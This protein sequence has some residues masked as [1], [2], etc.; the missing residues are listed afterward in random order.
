MVAVLTAGA[1]V[2]V[3]YQI[4]VVFFRHFTGKIKLYKSRIFVIVLGYVCAVFVRHKVSVPEGYSDAVKS[5]SFNIF[6]ILFGDVIVTVAFKKLCGFFFP[7]KK[8]E[9]I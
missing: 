1:A 6:K 8:R 9:F 2:H 3:K 4:Q 5:E 7:E